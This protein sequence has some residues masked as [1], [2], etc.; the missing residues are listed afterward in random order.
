MKKI[1]LHVD[2]NNA[3]LSW[4][5][6][7][8]IKNGGKEDIRDIVSVIGGDEKTRSGIVLAKSTKA[9]G[10]GIKTGDTLYEAR[11]KCAELVVERSRKEAYAEY[12]DSLYLML[13]QYSDKVE[14]YSIDECFVDITNCLMGRDVKTITT[15]IQARVKEELG[16]TVNIGIAD[17]KVLAK[18]ASDFEKPNKIHTLFSNEI[19]HKMWELSVSEL[20]MVGR[21]SIPKLKNMQIHTI[22]DLAARN[23]EDI[24]KL[25]G[26]HGAKM[27]EYANGIDCSEVVRKSDT[28]KSISRETT[29]AKDMSNVEELEK[30]LFILVEDVAITL[31]GQAL[32]TKTVSVHIRT[33]S[34]YDTSHQKKLEIKSNSTKEIY[35][36]AKEILKEMMNATT[37]VRLI[38][39]KLDDLEKEVEG[40]AQISIFEETKNEKE[41]AIDKVM[42]GL[43]AKFGEG[44][45]TRAK[46]I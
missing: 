38:G 29:L 5:A 40:N 16:F 41:E 23:K 6:I 17:S 21:S 8:I 14:R 43:K 13:N 12:S 3:F 4:T 7:E 11:K 46:R 34:F 22:G 24:V 26:K 28:N 32:T 15:E 33:S 27:W 31:R 2:V 36:I 25:F 1:I 19:A 30:I 10:L 35:A 9:K 39:V 20:F 42:D 37:L 18:M 44:I 45:I